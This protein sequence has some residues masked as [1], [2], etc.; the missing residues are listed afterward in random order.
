MELNCRLKW[1]EVHFHP[2]GTCIPIPAQEN[3]N[4]NNLEQMKN[5]TCGK[6]VSAYKLNINYFQQT[7]REKVDE[8]KINSTVRP[9]CLQKEIRILE[10]KY[11][12]SRGKQVNLMVK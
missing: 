6:I 3:G 8:R 1:I 5:K 4:I 11:A 2:A 10:R 9:N 7:R 12:F